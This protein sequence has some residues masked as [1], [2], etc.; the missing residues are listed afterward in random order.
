MYLKRCM[1]LVV[2]LVLAVGMCSCALAGSAKM[3]TSEAWDMAFAPSILKALM[4]T[5]DSWISIWN[6]WNPILPGSS[7]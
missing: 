6:A 1:V 2:C 3:S 4:R 5:A 7:W